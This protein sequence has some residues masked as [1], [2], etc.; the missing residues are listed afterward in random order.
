MGLFDVF[1]PMLYGE[2]VWA[3]IMLQAEIIRKSNDHSILAWRGPALGI[4][5]GGVLADSPAAFEHSGNFIR[6]KRLN[7]MSVGLTGRGVH[8]TVPS[9]YW[10]SSSYLVILNCENI[11]K[12]GQFLA[13]FLKKVFA[14][15]FFRDRRDELTIVQKPEMMFRVRHDVYI[16]QRK[17]ER[18]VPSYPYFIE[19]GGLKEHGVSLY[20]TFPKSWHY[21]NFGFR[22][23]SNLLG[24][25]LF[26][27]GDGTRLQWCWRQMANNSL[28][29]H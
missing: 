1:M 11:S 15:N 26:F 17:I 22:A 28:P 20:H 14:D 19:M 29:L 25:L 4:K 5:N 12:P 21:T 27:C 18:E 23:D 24:T 2:E 3:F 10:T 13:I 7:P 16:L 8:L 6:P 9:K